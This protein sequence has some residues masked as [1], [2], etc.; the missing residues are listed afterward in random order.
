M[1][2]I[3]IIVFV[4]IFAI[5][6]GISKANDN[7]E[8]DILKKEAQQEL[9]IVNSAITTQNITVSRE[10]TYYLEDNLPSFKVV[11]DDKNKTLYFFGMDKARI[12]VPYDKLLGCEVFND[13]QT[14]GGVGRAVVGGLIAGGAG[15]IVG[16]LTSESRITSMDLI[17]YQD[18][19]KIP[20][21]PL[22]LVTDGVIGNPQNATAFA[23]EMI[24]IIKVILAQKEGATK[25]VNDNSTPIQEVATSN[26]DELRKFK[27][28][29]ED[30]II[31]Q[32]EFEAKKKQ[33]LGL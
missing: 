13:K 23:N 11:V 31:T 14:V 27:Q 15:A 20:Q 7:A 26:A 33:L 30:G 17:I 3:V 29:L 5:S 10:L 24:A 25:K 6:R 16:T 1:L 28:L 18:D 22:H 8:I 12:S 32:E 2:V 21:I 19:L 9:S 4:I